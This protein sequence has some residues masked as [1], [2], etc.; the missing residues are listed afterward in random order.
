MVRE[1]AFAEVRHATLAAGEVLVDEGT[2]PS[3]VYL[4]LA[5]GLAVRPMGGYAE[6]E[7]HPW[8]PVGATGAIRRAPRNATIIARRDVD[9][10]MVPSDLYV[11]SWLRPLE[12]QQLRDRLAELPSGAPCCQ[13]SGS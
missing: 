11:T 6:A 1:D 12:P 9:V 13:S 4:P 10:L 2:P 8:V 3:F 7:L 5:R